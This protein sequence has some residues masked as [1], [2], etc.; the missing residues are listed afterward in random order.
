MG[1]AVDGRGGAGQSV[2]GADAAVGTAGPD[3]G[4][5]GDG[6]EGGD[7]FLL[8]VYG[9]LRFRV[10]FVEVIEVAREGEG[11]DEVVGARSPD[12]AN[13]V[14]RNA[15]DAFLSETPLLRAFATFCIPDFHRLIC[16]V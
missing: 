15:D 16:L 8:A 10:D 3:G 7:V 4:G 6:G 12:Y 1:F 9:A 2:D 5:G 13:L 14:V 11:Y